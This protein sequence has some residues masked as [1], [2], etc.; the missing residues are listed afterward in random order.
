MGLPSWLIT[1]IILHAFLYMQANTETLSLLSNAAKNHCAVLTKHEIVLDYLFAAEGGMCAALNL[2][3]SHCCVLAPDPY[4]NITKQLEILKTI[5]THF[6]ASDN[7]GWWGGGD[8]YVALVFLLWF[9]S[10]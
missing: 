3:G 9:F 2:T 7:A 6:R 5:T 8:V 10:K 1:L 4:D